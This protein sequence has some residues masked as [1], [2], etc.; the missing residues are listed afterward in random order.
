M[1]TVWAW[2]IAARV[3]TLVR[4]VRAGAVADQGWKDNVGAPLTVAEAISQACATAKLRFPRE[5][6]KMLAVLAR[7]GVPVPLDTM[8]HGAAVELTS[9]RLGLYVGAGVVESS[10][11]ALCLVPVDQARLVRAWL[12][13]GLAYMERAGS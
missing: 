7:D 1:N 8:P 2:L 3:C 12:V 5:D 10:G 9:G 13:P 4:D 11:P 6:A